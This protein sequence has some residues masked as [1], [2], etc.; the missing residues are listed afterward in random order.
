MTKKPVVPEG[1]EPVKNLHIEVP[2]SFHRRIKMLCVMKGQTL[3]AYAYE[4]LT[5][6]VA[7][8]DEGLRK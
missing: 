1:P 5:E 2:D 8:D 6:K 4:A 7:R 3:K